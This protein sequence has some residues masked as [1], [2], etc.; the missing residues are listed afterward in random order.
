MHKGTPK[1]LKCPH[2]A[3][4]ARRINISHAETRGITVFI[5]LLH[6][7]FGNNVLFAHFQV[8]QFVGR[9]KL[10]LCIS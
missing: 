10:K 4:P 2:G 3:A 6:V 5:R 9:S 8:L 7:E 1:F